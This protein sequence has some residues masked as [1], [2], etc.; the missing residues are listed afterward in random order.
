MAD[1]EY[2]T[3]A[4]FRLLPDMSNT[5]KYTDAL[6][7]AA[8]A[9]VTAIVERE[10]NTSFIARAVTSEVHD[11][12]RYE[13]ALR[14]PYVQSITSATED[15]VAVTS[16]LRAGP[17][18]VLR[19]FSS[20]TSYIPIWWN[21]GVGNI[22][23]SYMAGYS[24]TV[25]SDLAEAVKQA[26]RARLMETSATSGIDDR[27]TALTTEMGTINFVIA[28]EGRPTGYPVVDE[29]IMGWKRKLDVF[30]FA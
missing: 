7:L 5:T 26:T 15:G 12:G 1:P 23:V 17:G 22:A 16:T 30:G 4:E 21:A 20:S 6:V 9:Y 25:P 10:C 27:R 29:V 24:A 8:A 14:S 3:L 18:G 28:G 13:I 11:G 19:R 2:F